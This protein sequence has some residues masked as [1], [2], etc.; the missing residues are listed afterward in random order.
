[1]PVHFRPRDTALLALLALFWG[2]SFLLIKVAVAAV[3][4]LWVVTTRTTVGSALLLVICGFMRARLPRDA[5]TLLTL[6]FIGVVGAALPWIAQAWAQ[7]FLDSG[8]LA[9]LNACTPVATLC[10]AVLAGQERLHRYRVVGLS[11]AVLGTLVI[12]RGE[13]SL[14][15]SRFALLVAVLATLGYALAS[16][17]TRARVSGRV[18]NL[19][20]AALQLAAAA[21]ATGPF[22]WAVNGPPP[23]PVATP[24]A[25]ALA[26]LGLLGTG[27]GFLIYFT[28][29]ENVG[30]TN[31]S[32]VT[33]LAPVV[34][35]VSGGLF[36][37]ER[38]GP[39]VFAGAA[40]LV[41]GVWLAAR[42]P[43][44]GPVDDS[45]RR[46]AHCDPAART[47]TTREARR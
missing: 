16:V 29:I 37:G 34:G 19:P 1:V 27:L 25:A 41:G 45:V 31:A 9:V 21:V 42:H 7:Q 18:P 6:L 32:M 33:Y 36:R 12:V 10:V 43:R 35:L 4:P 44:P 11:V 2:H 22:A 15:R 39:N 28:L 38:F 17:V 23:V 46:C 14:G 47:S 13:V 5:R 20:A 24:V 30:A 8:V 3:P 26:A 40:L